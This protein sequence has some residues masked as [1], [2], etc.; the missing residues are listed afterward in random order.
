MHSTWTIDY[1]WNCTS[2]VSYCS[3]G[4]QAVSVCVSVCA[5]VSVCVCVCVCVCMCV[6][7]CVC[8]SVSIL[9]MSVFVYTS[10]VLIYHLFSP[11]NRSF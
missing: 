4:R 7:V 1:L 6:S 11:D 8:V 5:C 3:I 2:V 9:C 10:T